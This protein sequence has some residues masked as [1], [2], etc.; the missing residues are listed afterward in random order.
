MPAYIG[1]FAGGFMQSFL[2]ARAQRMQEQNQKFMQ[3]YYTYLMK[4]NN[5]DPQSGKY[6]DPASGKF[7]SPIYVAPE[8]A[9]SKA[10][11]EGTKNYDQGSASDFSKFKTGLIGEEG[12]GYGTINK[13]GATG[14]YQVMPEN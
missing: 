2:A 12:A 6:W 13:I 9:D 10:F 4:N 14:K 7:S 8:S 1:N 11:R 3:A 5:Y